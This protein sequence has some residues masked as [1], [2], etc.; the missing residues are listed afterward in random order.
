ML[1]L[2]PLQTLNTETLTRTRSMTS[3][4]RSRSWICS[5]VFT[6][7]TSPAPTSGAIASTAFAMSP[8]SSSLLWRASLPPYAHAPR[9]L[10]TCAQAR[11]QAHHV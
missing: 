3:S 9:E 4:R 11:A 1:L 10:V 7:P 2:V 5:R 6:R 8:C